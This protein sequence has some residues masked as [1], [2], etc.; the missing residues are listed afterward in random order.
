MAKN[1]AL[2]VYGGWEGHEPEK[3][4]HVFKTILEE[5]D[6]DVAMS[7][8]LEAYSDRDRLKSLNLIVPHWTMGELT[9][10]QTDAVVSAVA[11]GV[12]IAGCHAGLCDAFRGSPDWQFM[13]GGQLVA[14]VGAAG[15]DG[16]GIRFDVKVKDNRDPIMEGIKD[17]TAFDEQYYLHTDPSI[18]VLAVTPVPPA[19]GAFASDGTA[20][21]NF[22]FGFGNWNFEE[23]NVLAGPHANNKPIEMPVVYTKFWGKGRVF[24]NSLGHD[25]KRAKTEPSLTITKR[26][27]LWAAR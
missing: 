3:V 21:M 5:N 12:G 18:H 10:D 2:I 9:A 27:F 7:D 13:A 6:F 19:K 17:F 15:I 20:N 8:S 4:A 23:R 26:G 25:E 11:G 1:K 14:H 24:Y 22:D 16:K